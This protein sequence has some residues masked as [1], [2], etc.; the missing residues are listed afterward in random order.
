MRACLDSGSSPSARVL[1][2]VMR[3]G[4]L[5]KGLLLRGDRTVQLTLLCSRK[6]TR[7]LLRTISEQLPRQLP[8]RAVAPTRVAPGGVA[9]FLGDFKKQQ[10]W[11]SDPDR[12][13][14]IK[15]LTRERRDFSFLYKVSLGKNSEMM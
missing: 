13:V 2:G 15:K 3:V 4:L 14:V 6:P 10:T 7:A 9:L 8:V 5:A 1:K 11:L 12:V